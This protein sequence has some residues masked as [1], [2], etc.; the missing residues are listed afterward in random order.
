MSLVSKVRFF[1]MH[2]VLVERVVLF[3]SAPPIT[4]PSE[5]K[6]S[7]ATEFTSQVCLA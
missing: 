2:K 1:K 3:F 5:K 4:I 7:I 6:N